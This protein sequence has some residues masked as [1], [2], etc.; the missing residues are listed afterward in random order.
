MG[1]GR[2]TLALSS[3]AI[4]IALLAAT[5]LGNAAQRAVRS[6]PPFARTAG[7]AKLA[8]NAK[9]L[10]GHEAT[11]NGRPGTIP[12]LDSQGKLPASIGAVGPTGAQGPTGPGGPSGTA[13]AYALWDTIQNKL[14]HAHNITG[15]A[16]GSYGA[17]DWCVTLDKS[18]D[19]SSVVA[20]AAV[21]YNTGGTGIAEWS[22]E[23]GGCAT[24][25][26]SIQVWTL[27]TSG[28]AVPL[29]F[30]VIVP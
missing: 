30:T 25:P 2:T 16:Q 27:G 29:S 18:I 23:S 14:I 17:G 5:P 10:N 22:N 24:H 8:G 20:Q 15:V 3:T 26:N 21:E 19:A 4:L 11:T 28:M 1:N 12:I 7:Y 6:I 9:L 13:R